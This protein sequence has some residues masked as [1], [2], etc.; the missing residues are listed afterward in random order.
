MMNEDFVRGKD[1]I[2]VDDEIKILVS[3][4]VCQIFLFVF[5]FF[6]FIVDVDVCKEV[7]LIY[8]ELVNYYKVLNFF[9]LNFVFD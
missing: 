5:V 6:D 2:G 1:M 8:F 9:F 7:V 4:V 3:I